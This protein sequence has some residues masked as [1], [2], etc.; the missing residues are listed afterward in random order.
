MLRASLVSLLT[1]ILLC[2]PRAVAQTSAAPVFNAP[3]LGDQ[4]TLDHAWLFHPGDDPGSASPT[5]DDHSWL[6]IDLH[7]PLASYGFPAS[8]RYGWLRIHIHL[9]TREGLKA[10]PVVLGLERSNGRY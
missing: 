4:L 2:I 8:L 9:P 10:Q 7:K 1:V 3:D 6:P 5:L